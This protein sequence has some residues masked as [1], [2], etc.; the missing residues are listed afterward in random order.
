VRPD[1]TVER[2]DPTDSLLPEAWRTIQADTGTASPF[3]AWE[4]FSALS[5]IPEL[6]I[7]VQVLLYV[8]G[9]R[10]TGLLAVE[11]RDTG[12]LRTVGI[13]GGW[14]A[15]DHVDVL[16]RP[17]DRAAAARAF[18]SHLAKSGDWDL[19]D[20]DGLRADG[21]LAEAIDET[22]RSPRWV[23]RRD[24][25]IVA[26]YVELPT[27]GENLFSTRAR[28]RMRRQLCEAEELGG[29][30]VE[31]TDPAEVVELLEVLFSLHQRR[32][33]DASQLFST[34]QR[35]QFHRLASSRM[36]A[37][38]QARAY[39]LRA[40]D[41]FTAVCYVLTW[42]RSMFFYSS[43]FCPSPLRSSGYVVR[44][45]AL[46]AAVNEGFARADLLRGEHEWKH[47]FATGSVVDV[48]KRILRP[49]VRTL[50]A[51]G[52]TASRRIRSRSQRQPEVRVDGT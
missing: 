44:G 17:G 34:P 46:Q 39:A 13:A 49:S 38:G 26:P 15:P 21:A 37:A 7:G 14:L 36:A 43:G 11:W 52:A 47:Q 5:D 1:G 10:P 28:K 51:A 20:F 50:A 33:G 9:G 40:G 22:F 6:V 30:F 19:L 23:R 48:R 18:V 32:H 42:D 25:P 31:A 24:A 41:A 2:L 12:R 45:L 16:A 4:W 8:V 27:A 35:Q 3:L 29:G